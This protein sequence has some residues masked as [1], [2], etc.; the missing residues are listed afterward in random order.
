MAFDVTTIGLAAAAIAGFW[1]WLTASRT[2]TST[3]YKKFVEDL[4]QERVDRERAIV[5]IRKELDEERQARLAT[6]ELVHEQKLIIHAL[7]AHITKLENVVFES[8][9]VIPEKPDFV[10]DYI[11]KAEEPIKSAPK[12][13]ARKSRGFFGLQES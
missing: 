12:P 13:K 7:I 10:V 2:A 11:K 3:E 4:Q 6:D 9:G 5:A 8:G 1:A